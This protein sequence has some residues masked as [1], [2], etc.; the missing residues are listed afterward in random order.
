MLEKSIIDASEALRIILR[1]SGVADFSRIQ[2]GTSNKVFVNSHLILKDN[3]HE[4]RTSLYRP[5]SKNGDPRIWFYNSKKILATGDLLYLTVYN[6]HIIVIPLK[7]NDMFESDL[8]SYFGINE[9]D[10]LVL[11]ELQEKLSVLKSLGWIESVSPL[12]SYSKDVGDTLEKYLGIKPNSLVSADYKGQIELKCKRIKGSNPDTLFSM[13]PNWDISSLKSSTDIMLK[14]GYSS[15]KYE[16]FQDLYITVGNLPNRQ[17]LFMVNDDNEQLL[18]QK[19]LLNNQI[20]E[21]CSWKYD[22]VKKRL[23]EKHPKTCWIL[24]DEAIIEGKIHFKYLSVQLSQRPI[25][26]QFTTLIG[27]GIVTYD[28]RGR[29]KLDRT[30]YKDK[31]HC[32]RMSSKNRKLLFGDVKDLSI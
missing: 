30:G 25:F 8:I 26:S 12:R 23:I 22:E 18:L 29:V 27:Q 3:V 15:K 19:S 4:I 2:Q 21:V 1:E 9:K 11:N 24:A 20:E 17:G 10:D 13:V 31:G 6:N 28:W 14:Y 32:F 7:N 16:G 5:Q